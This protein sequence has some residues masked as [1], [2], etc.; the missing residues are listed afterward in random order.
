MGVG[1]GANYPPVSRCSR[2]PIVSLTTMCLVGV[3]CLK[4]AC[5]TIAWSRWCR[6]FSRAIMLPP[7]LMDRPD[8]VPPPP[9]SSSLLPHFRLVLEPS[10]AVYMMFQAVGVSMTRNAQW[11]ELHRGNLHPAYF[12]GHATQ[13]AVGNPWARI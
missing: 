1:F 6:A 11:F 7:L 4:K 8:L 9:H 2:G 3:G 13:A 5:T 12:K 10:M